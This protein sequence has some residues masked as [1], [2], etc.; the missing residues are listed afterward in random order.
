MALP[1]T[2]L[3]FH[4]DSSDTDHIFTTYVA[5]GAD[6]GTPTDGSA[7]QAWDDDDGKN[8]RMVEVTNS[9]L[10]RSSTPLM[11]LPCLDFDG[12]N[13]LM[14]SYAGDAGVGAAIS[15]FFGVSA[16]TLLG[17]IYIEGIATNDATVYNNSGI[18]SDAGGYWGV[19][20][21]NPS[22]SNYEIHFYNYV[23]GVTSF[24]ITGVS[25]NK[26]YVVV[27]RH[28]GTTMYGDLYDATG[29]V[30]TGSVSS[31]ATA[32][33]ASNFQTGKSW[34]TTYYNGRIGEFALYNAELTG[35]NLTD[36]IDY[37]TDKWTPGGCVPDMGL[38]GVGR[39]GLPFI[40]LEW[41]RRR[42]NKIARQERGIIKPKMIVSPEEYRRGNRRVA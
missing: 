33:L 11:Q 18:F 20:T 8:F 28:N 21:K 14:T 22:G 40:G 35:S 3:T 42:K 17:S 12:T 25:L 34:T 29:N 16:K 38:L 39:C 1:T 10:W 4:C 24:A 5:G 19:F 36:A 27:M 30:G 32:S 6:T 2:N 26:S 37:F 13:D 15:N 7:V 31:G 23:A 9:P 41:L